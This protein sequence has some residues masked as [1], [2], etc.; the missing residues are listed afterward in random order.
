MRLLKLLIQLKSKLIFSIIIMSWDYI[1]KFCL[2]GDTG[3][4]KSHM[5]HSILNRPEEFNDTTT[6]GVDY[7]CI[8]T[9]VKYKDFPYQIKIT[10]WDT[11]G[12][13][14]F[15]SIIRSYYKNV[16][17]I[18]IFFDLSNYSSYNSIDKWIRNINTLKHKNT[19]IVLI[20]NKL[21]LCAD[22]INFNANDYPYPFYKI[23]AKKKINTINL[24]DKIALN[25]LKKIKKNEICENEFNEIGIKHFNSICNYTS[26]N[27]DEGNNEEG[28]C[29]IIS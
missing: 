23:S 3:V 15:R 8:N 22:K 16:T 18:L 20:G 14:R 11:A 26:L 29:C 7:A 2:V 9:V 28:K 27:S 4:G 19:Q 25:V 24:F 6:I 13:E 1:F 12:Q 17:V 10:L 5:I 21:D